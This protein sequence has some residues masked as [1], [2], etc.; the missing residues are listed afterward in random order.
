VDRMAVLDFL[1][2]LITLKAELFIHSQENE[3]FSWFIFINPFT[4]ELWLMLILVAALT[5]FILLLIE[6]L[7]SQIIKII[8][9]SFLYYMSR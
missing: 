4:M 5:A 6:K 2:A 7:F 9:F 1:P 8:Y 3:A